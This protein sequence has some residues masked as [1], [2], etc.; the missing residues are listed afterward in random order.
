VQVDSIGAAGHTGPTDGDK[1]AL[2]TRGLMTKTK[3][4]WADYTWNPIKGYCSIGCEY[5]Y[6]RRMYDRF[7]W[8]KALRFDEQ[9]LDR[10]DSI[11]KPSRIFVGSTIE[12]YYDHIPK[13]WVYKIIERSW[14]FPEHTFITLTKA[15]WNLRAYIFPSWWWVGVT[16]DSNTT[17]RDIQLRELKNIHGKKFI[18]FEPLLSDMFSI[19]F[20]WA[21]W[22]II[23][24]L[25]GKNKFYPPKEWIIDIENKAD[26]FKIPIFEKNNLKK[27]WIKKPRREFSK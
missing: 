15:P 5:C 14:I 12:M 8:D 4:E 21:D 27:E 20:D 6:A 9:E 11:K 1:R 23:G 2:G 10:L 25:T 26:N 22:V 19:T 3:I 16:M 24:G 13:D 18:S 7:K 17:T